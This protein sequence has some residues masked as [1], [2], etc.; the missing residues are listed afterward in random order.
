[1]FFYFYNYFALS[2]SNCSVKWY[3]NSVFVV[4]KRGIMIENSCYLEEVSINASHDPDGRPLKGIGKNWIKIIEGNDYVMIF[5]LDN[6][7]FSDD[8]IMIM[9]EKTDPQTVIFSSKNSDF[10]VAIP[11]F[12]ELLKGNEIN[13]VRVCSTKENCIKK[14]IEH[15][16]PIIS[17]EMKESNTGKPISDFYFINNLDRLVLELIERGE[18]S[19]LDCYLQNYSKENFKET[20]LKRFGG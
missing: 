16:G 1:M 8:L 5:L 20:R 19:F 15:F 9:P 18:I 14:T 17:K 12:D 3:N 4:F 7:Y 6:H 13:V 11:A 10:D 2:L